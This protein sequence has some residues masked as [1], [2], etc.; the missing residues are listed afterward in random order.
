MAAQLNLGGAVDLSSITSAQTLKHLE[1]VWI[2]RL[3]DI[4]FISDCVSL[5]R[6]VLDRL[7]QVREIPPLRK[8]DKLRALTVGDLNGLRSVDTIGEAPTLEWFGYSGKTL[9]PEDFRVA[10]GARR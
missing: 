6:L 4:S 9:E 5:Q 8:L 2:R 10:L 1:L 3:S 7:R